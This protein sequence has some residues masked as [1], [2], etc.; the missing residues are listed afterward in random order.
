MVHNTALPGALDVAWAGQLDLRTYLTQDV[1]VLLTLKLCRTHDSLTL[2]LWG[3]ENASYTVWHGEVMSNMV[4]FSSWIAINFM[5]WYANIQC[6]NV[7]MAYLLQRVFSLLRL[8]CRIQTHLLR[9]K[10]WMWGWGKSQTVVMNGFCLYWKKPDTWDMS[11]FTT[12]T[13]F[14]CL[15]W[16][17]DQLLSEE[18]LFII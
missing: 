15:P 8:V 18:D 16:K 9:C 7:I 4:P 10:R 14:C 2:D 5:I 12:F 6:D 17:F 1:T 3:A 13:V 11:H